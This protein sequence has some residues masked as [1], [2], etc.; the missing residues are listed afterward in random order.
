MV[1]WAEEHGVAEAAREYGTTRVTVR[2]WRDRYREEGVEGLK[3]RSRRPRHSPGQTTRKVEKLVL[4]LRE[5]YPTFGG[6]RLVE[7]FGVPCSATTVYNVLKRHGAFKRAKRRW[8]QRRDLRELKKKLGFLG[9][10]Q[11]DVK[12]L[13]DIEEYYRALKRYELPRYEYTA[14]DVRTG[15]VII[16]FAYEAS[17]T[18]AVTFARYVAQHLTSYGGDVKNSYWQ[19]DNGAEFVGGAKAKR[20]SAFTAAVEGWGAKHVRIPPRA[21]TFNSDVEAFH[22]LVQDEF[23]RVEPFSS[24]KNFLG[25]AYTYVAYFNLQRPNRHRD[26]KTPFDIA[27]ALNPNLSEKLFA[28]PPIVLDLVDPLSRGY[29]VPGPDTSRPGFYCNNP[30]SDIISNGLGY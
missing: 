30:P 4:R 1:Q 14:R 29:H 20:P 27:S 22:R 12:H 28:P 5:R 21:P 17:L 8:R 18:N 16:A 26:N 13:K 15:M 9:K 23:Y 7:K 2:K 24:L 11:L 19:T 6:R 10:V 3:D 25:K